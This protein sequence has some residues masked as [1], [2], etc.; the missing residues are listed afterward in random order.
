MV[1]LRSAH[2]RA[3]TLIELLVV[4]A[5]IAVLIALLL[6]A[7]QQAREAAR[8]TQCKNGLKQ[9]GLAMHNYDSTYSTFP[10]GSRND[11]QGGFGPSWWAGVLPYMDQAPL[12]NKLTFSGSHCGWVGSGG[13]SGDANGQASNGLLIPTMTCPSSPLPTLIKVGNYSVVGP[14]YLGIAGSMSGNGF[15]EN[16]VGTCCSCCSTTAGN[17]QI[18]FG[19]VL[20]ANSVVRLRDLTD[21]TTNVFMVGECSNWFGPGQNNPTG[22]DGWLMGSQSNSTSYVGYDQGRSDQIT[23]INYPPNST[24]YGTSAGV[25][26][27]YGPNNGLASA[28]VGGAHV[29]L[30][31]GSVRFLSNNMNM[32]TLRALAT[33]DDGF[34]VGEF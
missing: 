22:T 17:G 13:G 16:R 8:R 10:I 24:I 33:R 34:P 30:G 27:N 31:D 5:I 14:H 23:T 2:K 15:T 12:Y 26:N 11:G 1:G 18:S 28:H 29:L 20:L 25:A 32:Q 3:F 4:I 21:G 9:I 19:G 6:P 7:V